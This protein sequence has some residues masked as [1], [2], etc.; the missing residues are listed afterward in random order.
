LSTKK[1]P[2]FIHLFPQK[3][4]LNLMNN[5][6][7]MVYFGTGKMCGGLDSDGNM[8]RGM[9]TRHLPERDAGL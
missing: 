3:A 7:L 5:I 8:C 1:K 6:I 2:C 9:R 4:G